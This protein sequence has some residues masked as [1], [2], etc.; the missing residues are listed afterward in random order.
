LIHALAA[1]WIGK[2]ESW[3]L[4]TLRQGAGQLCLLIE[5][6]QPPVAHCGNLGN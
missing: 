6:K 3:Q 4:S 5:E 1:A 2:W